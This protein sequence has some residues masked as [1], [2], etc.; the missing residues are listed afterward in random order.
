LFPGATALKPKNLKT[1]INET[2]SVR[3]LFKTTNTRSHSSLSSANSS[4][5]TKLSLVPSVK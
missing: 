1:F 3:D 2:L 4:N 5:E